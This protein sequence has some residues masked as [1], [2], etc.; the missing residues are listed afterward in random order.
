MTKRAELEKCNKLLSEVNLNNAGKIAELE[1]QLDDRMEEYLILGKESNK[2]VAQLD[3]A[4]EALESAI[5]SLKKYD[6]DYTII[7]NC[8]SALTKIRGEYEI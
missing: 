6:S 7:D 2:V 3:I 1:I 5:T 4:V 8:K